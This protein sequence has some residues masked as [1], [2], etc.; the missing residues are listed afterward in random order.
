[1]D[2][3]SLSQIV[4]QT[5]FWGVAGR[6]LPLAALGIIFMIDLVEIVNL[7]DAVF[8]GISILFFIAAI[9]WWWWSTYKIYQLSQFLIKTEEKIKEVNTS[10]KSIHNDVKNLTNKD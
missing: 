7:W 3:V 10:L 2:D 1:M 9:Y 8:T 4:K 5:K 6:I